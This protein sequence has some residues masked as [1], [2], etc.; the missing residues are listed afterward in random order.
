MALCSKDFTVDTDSSQSKIQLENPQKSIVLLILMNENIQDA[1]VARLYL[2]N[3][4][5][6]IY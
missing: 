4:Q 5:L 2:K 6:C 3:I 1:A